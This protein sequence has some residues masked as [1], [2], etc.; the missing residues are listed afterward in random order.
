[1][2][3]LVAALAMCLALCAPSAAAAWPGS[4]DCATEGRSGGAKMRAGANCRVLRFDGSARRYVAWV[5]PKA[6]RKMNRGR[7]VPVVFMLHGSSG[8]GEQF[9]NS[10]GW[11]EKADA[12]G[13]VAVFPTGL[14][15]VVDTEGPRHRSTRWSYYLVE[16]GID[17]TAIPPADDVGFLRRVLCDVMR[18]NRIDRKAAYLSGFSSGGA[19]CS[20]AALELTR[21]F[22]AFGCNAG[23]V[24]DPR[25]TVRRGAPFRP[26]MWTYGNRDRNML[27]AAQAHDPSLTEVPMD[28]GAA[29]ANPGVRD[30]LGRQLVGLRVRPDADVLIRRPSI[31]DLR[32]DQPVRQTPVSE[33]H[34]VLLDD[35]E[36][37][38]PNGCRNNPRGF[39]M[40]DMLWSFFRTGALG[41][42][43]SPAR[44]R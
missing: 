5:S 28:P 4:T 38:Y 6:K 43:A 33:L 13:F 15:Y 42:T 39:V 14:R 10:S 1:M 3:L 7:R 22:R 40:A 2:A 36:H 23:P 11:R 8:T 30:L 9:L 34:F 32:F 12:K 19:M 18:A 27:A 26:E 31:F 20:R 37:K 24:V 35:V 17:E 16:S 21:Q 44:C 25:R 29:V 41:Q